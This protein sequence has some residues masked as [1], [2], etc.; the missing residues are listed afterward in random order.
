[1]SRF[2]RA[3]IAG[4]HRRTGTAGLVLAVVA[5][6]AALSGGAYAASGAL[7]GKQKKEVE[8]I[9]KK[10]AGK[11][12]APG[13]AG[14]AGPTGPQGPAGTNGT[15]GTNGA[16]VTSNS[17]PTGVAS[18]CE[19]RGGSEFTSASGTTFAC[20]GKEGK[21]G[22]A[23]ELPTGKTET[24]VWTTDSAV[25]GQGFLL[26]SITF[27]YPV[28]AA[29]YPVHYV[30]FTE[31]EGGTAPAACPGAAAEPEAEAGNLCVY[32]T[33]GFGA[34]FVYETNPETELNETGAGRMGVILRFASTAN[35]ASRFGTWALTAE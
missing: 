23:S 22:F 28:A 13:A 21:T 14:T 8:K 12:G 19:S 18:K 24:G 34:T 17:V 33:G 29:E 30:K 26:T 20:T 15:S 25:T 4:L 10:F 3:G 16:G 11:P 9:A 31:V 27:P 6:V 2:V 1:M 32:E 5:L 35:G 7:T